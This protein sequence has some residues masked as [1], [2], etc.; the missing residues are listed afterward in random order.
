MTRIAA[1]LMLVLA[2]AF[3]TVGVAG[4]QSLSALA[5][6]ARTVREQA[7]T[8]DTGTLAPARSQQALAAPEA[9][10]TVPSNT[11]SAG[12]VITDDMLEDRV[13]SVA[14]AQRYPLAA[15][16]SS[17]VGKVAKRMLVAGNP[18]PAFAVAEPRLITRGVAATI[19]FVEGGLA[20][21]AVAMPLESGTVGASVRLK[22][23][24]S[25]HVIT[26]IVQADGTVRV[27]G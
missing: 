8:P 16:R 3:G 20:I 12:D 11:I 21:R 6:E 15:S 10:L 5:D 25:G 1:T 14:N 18:I 13:F 27:G 4:A 9:I 17:L 7:K 19:V 2:A 23:I 22:N 26:G 24:D